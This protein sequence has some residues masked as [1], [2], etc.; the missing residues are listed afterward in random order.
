MRRSERPMLSLPRPLLWAFILLLCAQLFHHHFDQQRLQ[1]HYQG[2]GKPFSAAAYRGLAMGSERSR[3]EIST[4]AT[5]N[6][7]T[8]I[9]TDGLRHLGVFILL[10]Y[11]PWQCI[12]LLSSAMI[13]CTSSNRLTTDPA[14]TL[15]AY[16]C[17]F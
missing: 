1:S 2:L 7:P 12:G 15:C 4:T 9:N 13:H 14:E 8:N 16:P 11:T 10:L 17:W 6:A 5:A 3:L